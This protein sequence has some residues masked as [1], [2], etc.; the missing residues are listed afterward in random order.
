MIIKK[1]QDITPQWLTMNLKKFNEDIGYEIRQ[2]EGKDSELFL[3]H[4]H[5]IVE[6]FKASVL[7]LWN[8]FKVGYIKEKELQPLPKQPRIDISAILSNDIIK[9]KLVFNDTTIPSWDITCGGH[10]FTLSEL[11]NAKDESE[12]AGKDDYILERATKLIE[13]QSN[14]CTMCW[15]DITY[16]RQKY[17]LPCYCTMCNECLEGCAKKPKP[18]SIRCKNHNVPI[19]TNMSRSVADGGATLA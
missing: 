14:K 2:Y 9:M 15:R 6:V 3:T 18:F 17:V 1:H 7:D 11:Q 12:Q 10:R 8:K 13:V 16:K 5:E 4:L 19:P